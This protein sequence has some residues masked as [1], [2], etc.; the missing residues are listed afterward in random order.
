VLMLMGLEGCLAS[1]VDSMEWKGKNIQYFN[2]PTALFAQSADCLPG[3]YKMIMQN[4]SCYMFVTALLPRGEASAFCTEGA[5]GN[6]LVAV[7]TELHHAFIVG[8]IVMQRELRAPFNT[9]NQYWTSGSNVADGTWTWTTTLRPF[10]YTKFWEGTGQDPSGFV[11]LYD[12]RA[13]NPSLYYDW[14]PSF[15]VEEVH[16]SICQHFIVNSDSKAES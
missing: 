10:N 9:L 13:S 16:R 15:A 7:E 6:G 8:Q 12:N 2:R 4:E 3:F 14:F 5:L 1:N 11:S